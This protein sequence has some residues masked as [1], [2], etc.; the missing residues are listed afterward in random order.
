MAD[1]IDGTLDFIEYCEGLKRELRNSWLSD[2]RQESVAE[3]SWRMS[4]MAIAIAPRTKLNLDMKKVL[5]MVAIH[6]V[7]E[8]EAGDVPTVLHMV[9]KNVAL[10]KI[11]DETKAVDNIRLTLG[12]QLGEYI[13][14]LWH[15]FEDQKTSEAKFVK[16]LDKFEAIVQKYQASFKSYTRMD[17]PQREGA[18]GYIEMVAKLC[19]I[20][21]YLG[22]VLQGLVSRRNM[23]KKKRLSK[24]SSL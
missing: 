23:T 16:I 10:K 18:P 4:M 2:D 21:E 6:D 19:E 14:D 17:E 3:H 15:E 5:E 7:A 13:Y 8:I 22:E 1:E 9:D 11:D 20:D 24:L 12:D